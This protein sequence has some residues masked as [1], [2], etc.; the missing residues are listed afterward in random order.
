[1]SASAMRLKAAAGPEFTA[2]DALIGR[3]FS[4]RTACNLIVRRGRGFADL[5]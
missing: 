3:Y 2:R 1:M 5:P 4:A